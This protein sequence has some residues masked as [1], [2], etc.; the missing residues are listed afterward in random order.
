[1]KALKQGSGLLLAAWGLSFILAGCGDTS[2]EKTGL[3][4]TEGTP[5]KV[6]NDGTAP[7]SPED[8]NK[9]AQQQAESAGAPKGYPKKR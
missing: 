5:V 3:T 4:T 9:K 7:T 6:V 1:M 8:Y 2:N